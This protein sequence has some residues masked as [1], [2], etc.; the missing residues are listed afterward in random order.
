MSILVDQFDDEFD[1]NEQSLK[2]SIISIVEAVR[3]NT[4][5]TRMVEEEVVFAVADRVLEEMSDYDHDVKY[6][7][8][9]REV[10]N[11]L[12]LATEGLVASGGAA[13]T[14]LLPTIHP[15]STAETTL[16]SSALRV[17]QA[18][19]YAA[20]ARIQSEEARAIVAALY[21]SN[22]Y[23]IDYSYNMA[24]LDR[25]G[26]DQVPSDLLIS[27]LLA[28]GDPY[29]GKNSSWHRAMRANNQ[30]RDDEGQFAEMGGGYRFYVRNTLGQLLSVVG[31]VAGIPEN[32]PS[33]IDIEVT[34]VKGIRDGI[35]T[36]P[37]E[38]GHTF[39]AILPEHAVSKGVR[40]SP[41]NDVPFIDIKDMKRKE[42]PTS[43]YS[44]KGQASVPGLEAAPGS[45]NFATGDGYQA[46][47]YDS[48]TPALEK[49]IIGAQEMFGAQI[50]SFQGTDALD[51]NYPVYELISTKRGQ[52]EVVG[53]AQ[54]WASLQKLTTEEDENY[55]EAENEPVQSEER[56]TKAPETPAEA[57]EAPV[58]EDPVNP[59]NPDDNIP[60]RWE[61]T[62]DNQYQSDDYRFTAS[63][64]PANTGGYSIDPYIDDETGVPINPMGSG[65]IENAFEVRNTVSGE[66]VGVAFD[67]DGVENATSA[68]DLYPY[69]SEERSTGL[70]IEESLLSPNRNLESSPTDQIAKASDANN[71]VNDGMKK[72]LWVAFNN[73]EV[74]QEQM[75]AWDEMVADGFTGT[76]TAEA[77][78]LLINANAMPKRDYANLAQWGPRD[79]LRRALSARAV[80]EDI[81]SNLLDEYAG[82]TKPQIDEAIA[83]INSYPNKNAAST[84]KAPTKPQT[85]EPTSGADTV[86]SLLE[87]SMQDSGRAVAVG[88]INHADGLR[89]EY[90]LTPEMYVALDRVK[91]NPENYTWARVQSLINRIK[92]TGQKPR[93][94]QPPFSDAIAE[95]YDLLNSPESK[96]TDE[97]KQQA[98]NAAISGD[99]AN[100]RS[101][102]NGVKKDL[103]IEVKY[104]DYGRKN[105]NQIANERGQD[106]AKPQW[107]NGDDSVARFRPSD[108]DLVY[109]EGLMARKDIPRDVLD[110][111]FENWINWPRAQFLKQVEMLKDYPDTFKASELADAMPESSGGPTTRML[112]SLQRKHLKGLIEDDVWGNTVDKIAQMNFNAVG[113]LIS[114]YE[115]AED[116]YDEKVLF[117]S[118]DQGYEIGDPTIQGNSNKLRRPAKGWIEPENYV[119]TQKG[120]M[121][122]AKTEKEYADAVAAPISSSVESSNVSSGVP[123]DVLADEMLQRAALKADIARFRSKYLSSSINALQDILATRGLKQSGRNIIKKA[124]ADLTSL[125]SQM[126]LRRREVPS[127][128]EVNRIISI[129]ADAVFA[130][131]ETSVA[132][133]GSIKDPS[134][135]AIDSLMR[136]RDAISRVQD[137]YNAGRFDYIIEESEERALATEKNKPGLPFMLPAAFSGE[138]FSSL[139]SATSYDEVIDFLKNNDIYLID[140]ETTGL[141]DLDDL[142]VKNDPI[143]IAIHKLRNLEIVDSR[144]TYMNPGSKLSSYTLKSIGDKNGGR[145]T[146]EFLSKFENKDEVMRQV[147]DFIPDGAIVAGHNFLIFDKEVLDRSLEDAGVEPIQYGGI[148]DTLGLAKYLM[149]EWTPQNPDAAFKVDRWGNQKASNSLEALVT[150]FGLSN[151]GRHEA[152][153][154]VDSTVEVLNAMLDR[155]RRGLAKN[156]RSFNFSETVNGWSKESYDAAVEGYKQRAAEYLIRR[157]Q[158]TKAL[159][160]LTEQE[161]NELI[162]QQQQA[163]MNSATAGQGDVV[164]PIFTPVPST[165][166]DL[167]AGT[168][169]FDINSGRIGQVLGM[170]TDGEVSVD[171]PTPDVQ[172]SGKFVPEN[173]RPSDLAVVNDKFISRNGALL[174]YGMRV[175][176]PD[177]QAA[178]AIMELRGPDSV[179]VQEGG[180]SLRLQARQVSASAINDKTGAQPEHESRINDLVDSLEQSGSID[181][182]VASAYRK[183]TENHYYTIDGANRVILRL[184]NALSDRLRLEANSDI[185]LPE[186]EDPAPVAELSEEM[187]RPRKRK[188]KITAK[189][190][191]RTNINK[192][193]KKVNKEMGFAPTEEGMNI[194]TAVENGYKVVVNAL[195]GT[196][197]TTSMVAAAWVKKL[198]RPE[199]RGAYIVYNTHNADSARGRFPDN[200]VPMTSHAVSVNSDANKMM[201]AKFKAIEQ[202]TDAYN[203]P[204]NPGRAIDLADFFGFEK[205]ETK[206]PSNGV[207]VT[208]D[209]LLFA[210]SVH[211]M[212]KKWIN[213]DAM[214]FEPRFVEDYLIN[215]LDLGFDEDTEIDGDDI[216][217]FL[218]AM[219]DVWSEMVSAHNPNTNQ[220]M[221]DF[222][223]MLKNWALSKPNLREADSKGRS[224]H[225]LK[226]IPDFL[227]LDE[228]QDVNPVL[229]GVIRD[230]YR[231]TKR[232]DKPL[233][234]V[235]VGDTNQS[236][237]EHRG[238]IDVLGIID[239]DI[240]LPLTESF[241]SGEDI[242]GAPNDILEDLDENL[243]LVGKKGLKS[244]IVEPR[245]LADLMALDASKFAGL[246]ITRKNI[247]IIEVGQLLDAR[248]KGEKL[249]V[250]PAFKSR[251]IPVLQWLRWFAGGKNPEYKPRVPKPKDLYGYE[252][253][254][255]IFAELKNPSSDLSGIRPVLSFAA[256]VQRT[257]RFRSM[258]EAFGDVLKTLRGFRTRTETPRFY[259]PSVPIGA[260][261]VDIGGG[262]KMRLL[263]KKLVVSDS[264]W[265]SYTQSGIGLQE[266]LDTLKDI[267]FVRVEETPGGKARWEFKRMGETADVIKPI[268]NSLNGFDALTYAVTAHG[269]KGSE[270]DSVLIWS[271]FPNP[272]AKDQDERLKARLPGERRLAYV[273][274]TR[275]KEEIDPGGLRVYLEQDVPGLYDEDDDDGNAVVVAPPVQ[276]DLLTQEERDAAEKERNDAAIAALPDVKARLLISKV[277]KE[278]RK[279]LESSY[280]YKSA[281]MDLRTALTRLA[282]GKDEVTDQEVFDPE[283]E[284]YV[285]APDQYLVTLVGG[286]TIQVPKDVYD[287]LTPGGSIAESE[288]RRIL[289]SGRTTYGEWMQGEL[290]NNYRTIKDAEELLKVPQERR[291]YHE[292]DFE[293][294]LTI[295]SAKQDLADLSS[296]ERVLV[297]ADLEELKLLES[298]LNKIDGDLTKGKDL[299]AEERS[300]IRR[301]SDGPMSANDVVFLSR[302]IPGAR[303]RIDEINFRLGTFGRFA[304]LF[305]ESEEM[306][307]NSGDG[308]SENDMNLPRP[309]EPGSVESP[310]TDSQASEGK[311]RNQEISDQLGQDLL[312]AILEEDALPWIM[313]WND[314][315]GYGYLPTSGSTGKFYRGKNLPYLQYDIRKNG[316]TGFRYYTPSA[317]K[318]MGGFIAEEDLGRGVLI[319]FVKSNRYNKTEEVEKP[320]PKD[321]TKTVTVTE[322]VTKSYPKV[323]YYM[324]YNENLL[325]GVT[326]PEVPNR[327]VMEASDVEKLILESYSNHPELNY[328][329]QDE[330]FWDPM[331]DA[332]YL[333]YRE[334]FKTEEDHI[335]TLFHELGHSTGHPNRLDRSDLLKDY[336][337]HKSTRAR[338]EL[339]AEVT[340]ALL[341][342]ILNVNIPL[343]QTKA[344]VQSWGTYLKDN[345]SLIIESIELANRAVEHILGGYWM[346]ME[347]GLV[348]ANAEAASII[349]EAQ[350]AAINEITGLDGEFNGLG[351]GLNYRIEGDIIILLGNTMKHKDLIKGSFVMH[352]GRKFSP[353]W[354]GKSKSWRINLAG[355]NAI[356]SRKSYL[357]SLRSDVAALGGGEASEERSTS[358]DNQKLYD[359][360]KAAAEFY[361]KNLMWKNNDEAKQKESNEAKNYLVSRGFE[362]A[363]AKKLVEDFDL[364]VAFGIKTAGYQSLY[365]YLRSRGFS[366]Q[367]IR[368]AGIVGVSGDKGVGNLYDS[369][370]VGKEKGSRLIFPLKDVD[371]N[372]VGFV[373]RALDPNEQSRYVLSKTSPVFTKSQ[374]LFGIDQAKD[375]IAE[376][377]QMIVVEGQMDV[378]A[379]HAAGIKNVVAASGTAFGPSHIELFNSIATDDGRFKEIVFAFDPDDAGK[380]AALTAYKTLEGSD[381]NISLIPNESGLDPADLYREKGAEGFERSAEGSY[382]ELIGYFISKAFIAAAYTGVEGSLGNLLYLI[383]LIS[384]PSVRA[385]YIAL[386]ASALGLSAS[387]MKSMI[388]DLIRQR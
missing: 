91:K 16:S 280:S 128:K 301:A 268:I 379:M 341:A 4:P 158:D 83:I 101:I 345:P 288:E 216:E 235:T 3:E 199:E 38:I 198:T 138:V 192:V 374:V 359:I 332:I 68:S 122:G 66:P 23:S 254:D 75:D 232:G 1:K 320:D 182:S 37:S 202:Q 48:V 46:S 278:S 130:V 314:A 355:E 137:K 340:S 296:N 136:A 186:G 347:S 92:A 274:L 85:E 116:A 151:N 270:E 311:T 203:A 321:P 97:E 114:D 312:K 247:G 212:L 236:I 285:P 319:S 54:D 283:T 72:A 307:R 273:A 272:M 147:R 19:W 369:M 171:F 317:V 240:S 322:E 371:G 224:I 295:E 69:I 141:P 64:G 219:S 12:T 263:K 34:G 284:K 174:D 153:A 367:D 59:F 256:S 238:T 39:K 2:F 47:R 148:L 249:A 233:Q 41:N 25:L 290:E 56:V 98:L 18:Q 253:L 299:S 352:N 188:D 306:S 349:P 178:Q 94:P 372:V 29:A 146:P 302:A 31:K 61:K 126:D 225:G 246:T 71:P 323:G 65:I 30:R 193:I 143:Q 191:D 93:N 251:Y 230:Q 241:R 223:H 145:V 77:K 271:D 74:S 81:A 318:N 326:L 257:K 14:D 237:N 78:T 142:D 211:N 239:R 123:D 298:A 221:I 9:I 110:A 250:T 35:Y 305:S 73:H 89:F 242:L 115:A 377:N 87:A 10:T 244:R 113:A 195:A 338:E 343:D 155:A 300:A 214:A 378:L 169:V 57:E 152:D 82:Y 119:P 286:Q 327:P 252:S 27:P 88:T 261:P 49:R 120:F 228:A 361:N 129:I 99:S 154:D 348:D 100:A 163:L 334:Q 363:V 356:E 258:G 209:R 316:Y 21:A 104:V 370:A 144:T 362:P 234:I 180:S 376:T 197:K 255:Q 131:D 353:Y 269:A 50:V 385:E 95:L 183:A 248:N 287:N 267:G 380:R 67:W 127:P 52:S 55:P 346:T 134:P 96:K 6:F 150:Y 196:G 337:S 206:T 51:P 132:P 292:T 121:P 388:D 172:S 373:G 365:Q 86:D 291:T 293:L 328:Q 184:T 207:P 387:E 58:E 13:H 208:F 173:M 15:K 304:T 245:T 17:L 159:E 229:Y 5:A 382:P 276:D 62:G 354:H 277:S 210:S 11:F 231:Y 260:E 213:S 149:P 315:A 282:V 22:P 266:N 53:Y 226:F 157:I 80:P 217:T 331:T 176:H 357:S 8:V 187:A 201:Y 28:F 200:I 32:S 336:G 43:W 166:R 109:A 189:D 135:E 167:P 185:D 351:G 124:M 294:N 140:F 303:K 335:A 33:G 76:N 175:T 165:I 84:T 177:L 90:N 107:F 308:V 194:L 358:G 339:V 297:D 70:G 42:L 218:T 24:R 161:A 381:I 44:T 112:A 344:Y 262:L 103:G 227:F 79:A 368:E 105:A 289:P 215:D 40:V 275:A 243:R 102:L 330:A 325:K 279:F 259:V 324:V 118:I 310:E 63:Y 181:K 375:R 60:E 111:F 350:G 333:P 264:Q 106:A 26:V 45:R 313:P 168:Y 384:S 383:S 156:G 117:D 160:G 265:K 222:D 125:R 108:A 366:G 133:Y 281:N 179:V 329:G 162:I 342:Q 164:D 204:I 309:G 205:Y 190:L 139:E 364:G 36:I 386:Y 7:H 20:D 170:R 220:I 360:N